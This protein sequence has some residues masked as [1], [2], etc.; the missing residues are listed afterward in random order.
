MSATAD[1]ELS[2]FDATIAELHKYENIQ[3]RFALVPIDRLVRMIFQKSS[4][5]P[6]FYTH[7]LNK[8][9]AT[10]LVR[11]NAISYDTRVTPTVDN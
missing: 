10:Y 11:E 5:N 2:Q 1:P 7:S 8:E 6:S 3:Y 4:I 9:A